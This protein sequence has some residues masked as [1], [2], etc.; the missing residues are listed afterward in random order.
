MRTSRVTED[1]R[2]LLKLPPV[3]PHQGRRVPP[4]T[5]H[6]TGLIVITTDCPGILAFFEY[7]HETIF[8]FAA[9]SQ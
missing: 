7:F 9:L 5:L 1:V 6:K 8:A 4:N 3:A 2:L